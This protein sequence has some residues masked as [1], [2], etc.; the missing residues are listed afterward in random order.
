MTLIKQRNRKL[1]AIGLLVRLLG[2]GL[3]FLGDGHNS[4]LRKGLVILGVILL[5]GGT[6]VLRYLLLSGPLS[7][8]SAHL[9]KKEAV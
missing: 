7:R 9:R 1:F 8:L 6:T 2:V 3:I 5:I 4:I